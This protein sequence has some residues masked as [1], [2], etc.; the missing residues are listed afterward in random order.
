MVAARAKPKRTTKPVSLVRPLVVDLGMWPF[1]A[2]LGT[3][4]SRDHYLREV[5]V[6]FG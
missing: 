6:V 4:S 1:R 5:V 2:L 3:Y